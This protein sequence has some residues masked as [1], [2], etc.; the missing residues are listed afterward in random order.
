MWCIQHSVATTGS[1]RHDRDACHSALQTLAA[2]GLV[3]KNPN[4]IG[5]VKKVLFCS[6][7]YFGTP[8]RC[9]FG[10]S[11]S[12][13]LQLPVFP[14][15]TFYE[16]ATIDYPIL[17]FL[18]MLLKFGFSS[19][20]L[21]FIDCADFVHCDTRQSGLFAYIKAKAL[22]LRKGESTRAAVS[23]GARE[24]LEPTKFLRPV[25]AETLRQGLAQSYLGWSSSM[26]LAGRSQLSRS[27]PVASTNRRG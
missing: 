12:R 15:N 1:R 9:S 25:P 6:R 4:R 8:G 5:G 14:R 16:P 7:R 18:L 13:S 10:V 11:P 19:L 26:S 24:S 22:F 17:A 2:S 23:S 20:C 27:A 3:P 21:S